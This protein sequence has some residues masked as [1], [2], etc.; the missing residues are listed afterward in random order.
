MDRVYKR[1]IP[2]IVKSLEQ[3]KVEFVNLGSTTDWTRLRI[4]PLLEHAKLL[5]RRLRSRKFA[6]E[7]ARLRAGV[8][9]FHADLVYFGE[10]IRG[11][12]KILAS[13]RKAAQHRR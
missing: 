8:G 12:R 4:E 2:D 11:L 13:E 7:T 6:R 5:D 1:G 3:L 9:M 10:N